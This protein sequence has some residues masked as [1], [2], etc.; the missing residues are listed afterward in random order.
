V[1]EVS[2]IPGIGRFSIAA[3]GAR[4]DPVVLGLTVLLTAA[5]VIA[6]LL[7][8]LLHAALEPRVR[9]AYAA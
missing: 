9:E 3:A 8:D 6:N 1:E 4:D 2:A 7:V 5:I